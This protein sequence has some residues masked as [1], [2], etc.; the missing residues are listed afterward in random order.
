LPTASATG[1]MRGTAM[2][3]DEKFED[4]SLSRVGISNVGGEVQISVPPV[5]HPF[6]MIFLTVWLGG[7]TVGGIAAFQQ[8]IS[9]NGSSDGRAFLGFWL[10]GWLVGE[11]FALG[12]LLWMFFGQENLRATMTS[13]SHTYRV[14]LWT[15]TRNYRPASISNLR[16]QAGTG[17]QF[18]RGSTQSAIAFEYGPK[19]ISVAKGCDAGEGAHIIATMT[20]AFGRAA[21]PSK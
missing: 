19:T 17:T 8:F 9:S 18:A 12:S 15:R 14:L 3:I 6:V 10:C 1:C 21:R 7:W 13:L 11:L 20:R 2:R 16:W 4:P 5:R